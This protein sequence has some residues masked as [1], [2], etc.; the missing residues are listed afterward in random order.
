MNLQ[1]LHE[2]T[3]KLIAA[4]VDE[5]LSV[6]SL[7]DGSL[8]EVSGAVMATGDFYGDPSPKLSAFTHKT[9]RVLVLVPIKEDSSE[10][11][12]PP[13]AGGQPSHVEHDLPVD[14]PLSINESFRDASRNR[15][16]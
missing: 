10:L 6:A 1:Q 15:F 5:K 8:C 14:F 12:N 2:W 4:G 3:G 13:E 11:F 7:V 16:G 9:G